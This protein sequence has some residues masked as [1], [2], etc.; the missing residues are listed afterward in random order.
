MRTQEQACGIDVERTIEVAAIEAG[1][2]GAHPMLRT[3]VFPPCGIDVNGDRGNYRSQE[4]MR[5]SDADTA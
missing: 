3:Q 1:N 4:P 2:P 5:A